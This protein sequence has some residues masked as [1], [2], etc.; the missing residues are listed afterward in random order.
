MCIHKISIIGT[1]RHPKRPRVTITHLVLYRTVLVPQHNHIKALFNLS[2]TFLLQIF[3]PNR[4][5]IRQY[6]L[7]KYRQIIRSRSI[8]RSRRVIYTTRGII[9][10]GQ[11]TVDDQCQQRLLKRYYRLLIQVISI[12]NHYFLLLLV[13]LSIKQKMTYNIFRSKSFPF[14]LP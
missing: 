4:L 12:L 2:I 7:V 9:N 6:S 13:T 10:H 14:F 3:T 11:R 8:I 1:R 5:V